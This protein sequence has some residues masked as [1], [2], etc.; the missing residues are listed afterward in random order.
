MGWGVLARFVIRESSGVGT[1]VLCCHGCLRFLFFFARSRCSLIVEWWKVSCCVLL[2]YVWGGG[3]VPQTR[4]VHICSFTFNFHIIRAI[5]ICCKIQWK[6]LCI[7]LVL[8]SLAARQHTSPLFAKAAAAAN[9]RATDMT[10]EERQRLKQERLRQYQSEARTDDLSQAEKMRVAQEF[11][12]KQKKKGQAQDLNK[13]AGEYAKKLKE[14]NAKVKERDERRKRMKE[15]EDAKKKYTQAEKDERRRR[16]EDYLKW[17]EAQEEKKENEEEDNDFSYFVTLKPRDLF[18]GSKLAF[19]N[20]LRGA[21]YGIAAFLGSPFSMAATEGLVG[22][23]KGIVA[24]TALGVGMPIAGAV[25]GLFQFGRG[26]IAQPFA[27]KDGFIDCKIWNE[28]ERT[29]EKYILDEDLD[30]IR[31]ALDEEEKKSGSRGRGDKADYKSSKV[32]STEYYDLLG[33]QPDATSSQ[34]RSAYRKMARTVHPDKNPDDPDAERKFRE[35]SAAYQTLSDSSKRK[36]Y[37]S[38]G[39]GVDPEKVGGQGMSLDPYVFFAVLF[40]S[41][42]VE[43][44]IGELGKM[45]LNLINHAAHV[46]LT[47]ILI[48]DI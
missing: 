31:E 32:K 23:V 24:G 20:V 40:G 8:L 15:R 44:Y 6:P 22:F 29:W 1:C 7:A 13:M 37:D 17:K 21:F 10:E 26:L 43:N 25:I 36:Q 48:H 11:L 2:S 16:A 14:E 18:E 45:Q 19:S 30:N 5:M 33:V 3:G 47:H 39:V 35:L 41:E 9:Q 42:Q 46:S 34:I 38:S 4:A 12:D 27:F 28:T